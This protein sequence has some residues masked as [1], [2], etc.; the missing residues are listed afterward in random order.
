MKTGMDVATFLDGLR[1]LSEEEI[2]QGATALGAEQMT[3]SD[4]VVQWRA[5][6]ALD[7]VLRTR[8]SRAESQRANAIAHRAAK[9]VVEAARLLGLESP[10]PDIVRVARAAGQIAR[11]LALNDRAGPFVQVM[12]LRW[13]QAMSATPGF[14][15][16]A[17]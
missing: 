7:R 4:Q 1:G 12:L 5:E 15:L 8:C 17:A 11:G 10:D 16:T 13:E 6:L 9:T 2:R 14:V 3:V